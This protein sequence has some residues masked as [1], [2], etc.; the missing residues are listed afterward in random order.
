MA[1]P[2]SILG[3]IT[4]SH[5]KRQQQ[6]NEETPKGLFWNP[7]GAGSGAA[8][9]I[10]PQQSARDNKSKSK[11]TNQNASSSKGNNNRREDTV[12]AASSTPLKNCLFQAQDKDSGRSVPLPTECDPRAAD[13]GILACQNPNEEVCYVSP[14]AS[15]LGGICVALGRRRRKLE[16]Q[17][18]GYLPP[19]YVPPSTD[20]PY[21]N[22]IPPY[23][24]P[25]PFYN[26]RPSPPHS[27][28]R[29]L[30]PRCWLW[31]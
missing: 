21:G 18:Y 16:Q 5:Q 30:L 23:L 27:L 13:I 24:P 29:K 25:Q 28:G 9:K 12:N 6:S 3:Q 31:R 4:L 22:I 2:D 11:I 17:P 20:Q 26:T 8:T 7:T 1:F 19:P 14:H 10:N 15:E